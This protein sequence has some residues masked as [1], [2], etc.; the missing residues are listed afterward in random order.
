MMKLIYRIVCLSL[1]IMQI[2]CIKDEAP[3][4]E[5]DIIACTVPADIL[6]RSPVIENNRVTVMVR[7]ETDLT[8]LAPEFE[9][10]PGATIS[11]ASGTV[12]DFSSSQ[13]YT[14][15]SE[16]G[17]WTKEYEVSFVVGEIQTEYHFENVMSDDRN[18]YDIFYEVDTETGT[19]LQWG[20]GNAG[21]ALTGTATGRESYPTSSTTDG[22]IGKGVK[23][24]TRESGSFGSMFGMPIAS[25]NI[26]MG[27]FDIGTA[28]TNALRALQ[29]GWPFRHE[30]LY[31]SGY[32]KYQAGTEYQVDGVA[33][34]DSTDAW[35]VYAV[36]YE[37]TEEEPM[38]TAEIVSD[39]FTHPNIV[40]V[41]LL[42][43]S[44][45]VEASEWTHFEIP[46]EM[47]EGK[48]IDQEKLEND[49]YNVAIVA[50]SSRWGNY[51]RGAPG[52]TLYI[53][54]LQLIY[55]KEE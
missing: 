8:A 55:R 13:Y 37:V 50:A 23:L 53:D 28:L 6:R 42:P 26:F 29:L 38:L 33:K 54:E 19:T 14:V 36:F 51:F 52:S 31:V 15:T 39:N 34:P 24:V 25:G 7:A 21:F 43:D 10:T 4:A 48:V 49:G 18:G 35:D 44:M 32:Y 16:D 22:Y 12:R 30:P 46:F 45:R 41:A 1:C 11:P 5:A 27:T 40:S 9:L 47:K 3:N 20:S 2:S 17:N